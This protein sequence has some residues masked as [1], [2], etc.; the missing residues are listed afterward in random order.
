[1]KKIPSLFERNYDG[2]KLVR[3][4][5]VPGSEWVLA[6][7]GVATRK[8]DG[9]AALVAEPAPGNL[10]IY[11]RYDRKLKDGEYKP[12]PEGWFECQDPDPKTGH[13]PGWTP[14]NRQSPEDRWFFEAFD[15]VDV[16]PY[17]GTYEVI[18]P[19]I[20]GNPER[21]QTHVLMRHGSSVIP[22]DQYTRSYDGIKRY[23]SIHDLEGIV[24]H[25]PDGRMVK[26]KAKDFGLKRG[27]TPPLVQVL[28]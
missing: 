15:A 13:W 23:L 10:T 9:T 17:V 21:V 27:E 11:K 20:N 12:A 8:W 4:E 3:D 26:I 19:K 6:G 14:C 16:G 1:M 22:E 7:E 28:L 18:G 2:D 25:H 5:V 24:W